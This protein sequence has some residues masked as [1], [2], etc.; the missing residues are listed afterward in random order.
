L[1]KPVSIKPYTSALLVIWTGILA[2]SLA[3]NLRIHYHEIQDLVLNTARI[4]WEKDL[5]YRRWNANHG[6]VYVQVNPKTPPNP[7]LSN[8]PE[9]DI[10]TPSGRQLTMVNPAYMTRQVYELNYE[11]STMRGHITSLLPLR[12][13]NAP[14]PWET[15]AL[16]AFEQGSG[17]VSIIENLEG[18][19]Y[20]RMMR[21]FRTEKGCLK[22]HAQQGYKEGDIR[23][24]LSVSI[25][26]APLWESGK[27]YQLI[28]WVS[29]VLIW[30]LGAAGIVWGSSKFNHSLQEQMR[31]AEEQEKL[32]H[33]LQ[34][35]MGQLKVLRGILPICANCKKI[36]D[37]K[38]YWKQVEVYIRDHSEADF[39]H[40]IC[41][42]CAKKLYPE[43]LGNNSKGK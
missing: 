12:K 25:P 19:P 1:T 18:K 9:R 22:C 36:R 10:I 41:P 37:D 15:S 23:G 35:A 5:L 28:I 13:E 21:P 40:S 26:M 3:W 30:L 27:R 34:E 29:H 16:K 6:G 7:F 33:K 38:G 8:V 39:S 43:Y 14:D 11:L 32:L 42:E 20:L 24:G 2:V 17:E 31:G 4:T